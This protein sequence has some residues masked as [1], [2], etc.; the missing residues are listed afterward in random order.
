MKRK[1]KELKILISIGGA[2]FNGF[3]S[4]IKNHSTRKMYMK[5]IKLAN[6][7]YLCLSLS[8][9]VFF[10]NFRFIKSAIHL[11]KKFKINGIDL[12][13]EWPVLSGNAKEKIK[14]I[15]LLYEMREEFNR[16]KNKYIL[17]IDV[18]ALK[19]IIDAAYNV[20]YIAE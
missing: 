12:D 2:D 6:T 1:R 10:C 17:S 9:L 20:Q 15:Q 11:L 4:M 14:F 19:S 8:F 18:A 5:Q 7:T 3:S 13:W 16:H